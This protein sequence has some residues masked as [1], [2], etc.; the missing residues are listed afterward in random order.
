M[1]P[2]A[3]ST[4]GFVDFWLNAPSALLRENADL[5]EHPQLIELRDK[6][7]VNPS[8]LERYGALHCELTRENLKGGVTRCTIE[9]QPGGIF[10][11]R[12]FFHGHTVTAVS[13]DAR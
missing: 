5:Q 9:N 12:V 10:S 4:V 11:F 8:A 13:A 1:A 6:I 3:R 7:I 2:F